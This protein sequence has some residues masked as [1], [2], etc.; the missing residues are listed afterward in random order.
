[1]ATMKRWVLFAYHLPREP[2]TPR[3]ALWRGLRR[4]G[5]AQIGDGLVALPL[6]ATTREQLEWLAAA[7]I[8]AG[9]ESSIWL[10]EASTRAQEAR[11][12][13]RIND[14]VAAEY[15]TVTARAAAAAALDEPARLRA[16]RQLR[17]ELRRVRAR[18]YFGARQGADA[19]AAVEALGRR[20]PVEPA[21]VR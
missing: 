12:V 17:R 7:V 5:C 18:D 8:E 14:G 11:W 10:G 9:G 4:L 15:A 20:A 16:L 3:I 1:M 21:A 19:E 6:N 2:S 13:G